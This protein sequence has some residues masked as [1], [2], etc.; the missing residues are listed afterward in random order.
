M[1]GAPRADRRQVPSPP[2]TVEPA[3]TRWGKLWPKLVFAPPI[4]APHCNI[5]MRLAGAETT[6]LARLF[7]DY[8]RIHSDKVQLWPAFKLK[9]TAAAPD[10]SAYGQIKAP[11]WLLME[12][13]EV[14][15]RARQEK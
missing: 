5:H 9:V 10:L 13:T 3:G 8:L 2:G 6:R 4:G 7:R 11:A 15:D 1:Q 14:W 12:L